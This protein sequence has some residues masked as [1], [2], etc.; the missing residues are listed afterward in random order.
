MAITLTIKNNGGA[1]VTIGDVGLT[2]A[3]TSQE[4]Y[5]ELQDIRQLLES[6]DLYMLATAGTL[7]LNDGTSDIPIAEISEF[8]Q[9]HNTGD[10]SI[11]GSGSP[12]GV[13]TGFFGQRYLNTD[14]NL[15][16]ICLS[17]PY[18]T[19]WGAQEEGETSNTVQTT[20]NTEPTCGQW[21][22]PDDQLLSV[23]AYV[24]CYETDKSNYA[25]YWRV[26]TVVRSGGGAIVLGPVD[27]LYTRESSGA[28]P[29]KATIDTSGNDVRIRVTG[30]AATTINWKSWA[31]FWLMDFA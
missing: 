17:N 20:D 5:T 27:T 11:S 16:W 29:W 13:V 2:I 8:I 4:T 25:V 30:A 18:G 15:W 31:K 7:V 22:V 21:T 6:P 24:L 12:D 23:S 3:A 26:A 14:D 9:L 19:S 28:G 1:A 10:P